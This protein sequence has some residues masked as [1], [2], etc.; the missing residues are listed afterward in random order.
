MI[1]R[2]IIHTLRVLYVYTGAEMCMLVWVIFN[3]RPP[4][5]FS[6]CANISLS[7]WIKA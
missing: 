5:S 1:S 7:L 3:L 4:E 2:L 6:T